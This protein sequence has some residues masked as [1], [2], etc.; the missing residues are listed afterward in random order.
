VADK[1]AKM[2]S[3]AGKNAKGA[4]VKAKKDIDG[5]FSDSDS[6]QQEHDNNQQNHDN[7]N[8][9]QKQPSGG[10]KVRFQI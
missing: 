9:K 7:E 2:S 5:D 8:N 3:N 1:S 4:M 10:N 6:D